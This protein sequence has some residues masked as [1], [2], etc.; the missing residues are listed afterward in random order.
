MNLSD[1]YNVLFAVYKS[2]LCYSTEFMTVATTLLQA[3]D[4][5]VLDLEQGGIEFKLLI[6]D[7]NDK[8]EAEKVVHDPVIVKTK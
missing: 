6:E 7:L 8:L 1:V 4:A 3:T 2:E 5:V